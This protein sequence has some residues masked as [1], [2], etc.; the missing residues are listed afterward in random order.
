MMLWAG[1]AALGA[2]IY[3]ASHLWAQQG[4][5]YNQYTT[6]AAAATSAPQTKIALVNFQVVV[7][8]YTR[9]QNFQKDLKGKGEGY[10][11]QLEGLQSQ[12]T[13]L[14]NKPSQPGVQLTAD[15]RDALADQIKRVQRDM[16]DLREKAT[17]ELGKQVDAE[18]LLIYKEVKE[19]VSR[20]AVSN[21]IELV[22]QYQDG[23]GG[24][25]YLPQFLRQK[26]TNNAC[27]PMY[28]TPAMD[29]TQNIVQNM[30]SRLQTM[31]SPPYGGT[32]Q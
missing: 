3:F 16:Q 5:T 6:Q 15:E 23:V 12:L 7:K 22:L 30:N 11:K 13:G 1:A 32:H 27:E 8:N 28:I 9:W 24:D 17:Q 19:A 14:Q 20:Y 25:E 21:N 29:I 10:Q 18:M 26:M 4:Q 31:S 2:G